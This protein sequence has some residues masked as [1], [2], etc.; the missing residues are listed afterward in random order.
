[1]SLRSEMMRFRGSSF[2]SF[3]APLPSWTLAGAGE[4]EE[5]YRCNKR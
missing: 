2:E 3:T 5:A 1:M 4:K